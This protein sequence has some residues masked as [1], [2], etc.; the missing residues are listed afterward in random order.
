MNA[1]P[2]DVFHDSRDQDVL[3]VRNSVDFDFL[4]LDVLVDEH[5]MLRR[6][7]YCLLQITRQFCIV[8]HDLHRT[9]ANNVGRAYYQRIT[10][11]SYCFK[12]FF[13][14]GN[15]KAFRHCDVERFQQFAELFTVFCQVDIMICSP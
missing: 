10:Q 13:F 14:V 15:G 12:S 4:T 9:S 1:R 7:R 2:L 11:S 3:A 8:I 5:R 6:K